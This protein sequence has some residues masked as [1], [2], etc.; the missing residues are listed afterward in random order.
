MEGAEATPDPGPPIL[1]AAPPSHGEII[2][3]DEPAAIA[4]I[5]ASIV[6]TVRADAATAGVA[7]RDAHPK[8]HGCVQA[9]FRVL[10]DLPDDLRVGLFATPH[11][12]QALI[13]F[14]N[15]NPK[16]QPDA[17]GDG[18]GMAIKVLSVSGSVS[19]TQD[20]ICINNPTFFVRNAPD[21]VDFQTKGV[22]RFILASLF[23]PK[24]RLHE[25][26][27]AISIVLKKPDNP[28][29]LQYWS[30]TPYRFGDTACKFSARPAGPLS[31]FTDRADPDF[32]RLNLVRHLDQGSAEFDFL[33]QRRGDPALMPVED[34]TI[35]WPDTSA[36]FI[37]VARIKI[38]AQAFDTPAQRA[39]GEAL[40]FTPWHALELHR[41]LGGINRVR[42]TVYETISRLRHEINH[43]VRAEP[44]TLPFLTQPAPD[45]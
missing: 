12:Y 22:I 24:I 32:L 29:N 44:A 8:M 1:P 25:A 38:P 30:M 42:R 41:P 10:A 18:R 45:S 31:P 35:A 20:F 28:L 37:P 7:Q 3:P 16:A 26:I 39:F 2:P 27:T 14:S 9:E 13:R 6:Q 4:T 19:T 40:S 11:C 43:Q 33:V 34:P 23:P 5:A 21:Y 36:P 15:G 17:K